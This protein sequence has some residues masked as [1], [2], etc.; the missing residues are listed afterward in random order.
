MLNFANRI[1]RGDRVRNQGESFS[2]L[3]VLPAAAA[4]FFAANINGLVIVAALVAVLSS[5]C[6]LLLSYH[7]SLPSGPAIILM[8]GI[9]YG[10]GLV[11]GPVG[12]LVSRALR[13]PQIQH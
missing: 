11:F 13:R 3:R 1:C 2:S 8:A 9:F 5:F 12:G 7:F 6:G 10:L 4:R